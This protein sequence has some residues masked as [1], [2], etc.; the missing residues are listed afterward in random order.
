MEI[1]QFYH[2]FRQM[3]NRETD[4]QCL[5][6]QNNSSSGN[7]NIVRIV[8]DAKFREFNQPYKH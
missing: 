4:G 3:E 7:F 6:G 8:H 2:N 1:K 5:S